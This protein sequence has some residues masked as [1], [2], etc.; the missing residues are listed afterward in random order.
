MYD[1]LIKELTQI[2]CLEIK[3]KEETSLKGKSLQFNF[4][5]G[6]RLY[7]GKFLL[8]GYKSDKEVSMI[9]DKVKKAMLEVVG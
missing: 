3:I 1:K 8:H 6:K 2:G 4:Y 9:V 7:Y 5:Y